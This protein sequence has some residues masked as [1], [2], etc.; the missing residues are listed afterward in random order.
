MKIRVFIAN[1][2]YNRDYY[3]EMECDGQPH[4]GD[5]FSIPD[6]VLIQLTKLALQ[7]KDSC[8][9]FGQ[10]I[11]RCPI[12][13]DYYMGFDDAFIVYEVTWHYDEQTDSMKC[14]VSL[15]CD[16]KGDNCHSEDFRIDD[17]IFTEEFIN[18]LRTNTE[19]HLSIKL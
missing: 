8:N 3:V 15:D 12:D 1:G 14:Y 7:D 18:E 16:K 9:A 19:K 4:Q 6:H 11:Y 2:N 10:W 17:F 13:K 5:F